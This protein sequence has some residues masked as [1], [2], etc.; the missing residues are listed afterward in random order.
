MA[1]LTISHLTKSFDGVP[2]VSDVSL[3][4]LTGEFFS[5]LGPSGC[6][7]TTLL[8]MVAGFETPDAGTIMLEKKDLAGVSPQKR[9]VGMVFQNYALF[10]HKTVF[11]NVAF[12]LEAGDTPREEIER[13]VGRMLE[14]VRL[15]AKSDSPVPSLSG[16]E[17]QR[18][19]VARAM[20][21]EPAIL[22]FDEPLSNLD[23]TLRSQTREEIRRLQR[24]SGITTLYVTHDQA[25]AMSLSHRIAI[26]ASGGIVQVGTPAELYDKPRSPFVAQFL[27]GANLLHGTLDRSGR[28]FL[29]EGFTFRLGHRAGGKTP[30]GPAVL[31]VKPEALSLSP[32]R[33]AGAIPA[34]VQEL[35]YLG[36]VTNVVV[37]AGPLPLR[38]AAA[39]AQLP[40]RLKAGTKVW[41]A[42][43]GTRCTVFPES[44]R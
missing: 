11:R 40:S 2:A 6:G 25:E 7:K 36:H 4:I 32:G 37:R 33:A 39:S 29:C 31:A 41:L 12:G 22:L 13:R 23:V 26:M 35:E 43:D 3:E 24:Q 28:T 14:R 9:S 5:I 27:G 18:V 8:R 42:V 44:P 20:V 21:V 19:A 16:G 30:P 38:I 1:S 10:P 17:Q 15:E 34:I